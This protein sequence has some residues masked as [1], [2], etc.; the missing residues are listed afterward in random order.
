M[1]F[2]KNKKS[3]LMIEIDGTKNSKN[4]TQLNLISLK[5][6]DNKLSIV[7][8]TLNEE[9]N[10]IDLESVKANYTDQDDIQ[11]KFI[12]KKKNNI[13]LL[14]GSSLNIN[15]LVDNLIENNEKSNI[16]KKKF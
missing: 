2:Q 6:N 7:D 13:Y 10:V 5:E 9:F 14:E 12:I 8:L 3:K 16:L 15:K 11:N 4:I 1:N